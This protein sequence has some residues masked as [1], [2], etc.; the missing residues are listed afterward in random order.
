MIFGG[1]K[2]P[3]ESTASRLAFASKSRFPLRNDRLV[4]AVQKNVNCSIFLALYFRNKYSP[5]LYT[6]Q[7]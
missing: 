2:M 4:A 5:C 6:Q 7:P 3:S 1:S